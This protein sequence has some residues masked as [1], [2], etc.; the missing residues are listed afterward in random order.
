MSPLPGQP[1]APATQGPHPP[2]S[3]PPP[4][5]QP[6][7]SVVER[8]LVGLQ[9]EVAEPRLAAVLGHAEEGALLHVQHQL[10]VHGLQRPPALILR[11]E[12]AAWPPQLQTVPTP[13]ALA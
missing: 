3:P 10:P 12:R 9:A 8:R 4:T 6:H 5:G 2:E 1:I 11:A 7:T 13:G